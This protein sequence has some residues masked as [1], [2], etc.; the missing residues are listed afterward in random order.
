MGGQTKNPFP[1]MESNPV[2]L[3]C[4]Q[5]RA[6]LII[7]GETLTSF[8]L[9]VV[10][11]R[12]HCACVPTACNQSSQLTVYTTLNFR[13]RPWADT[14]TRLV[15]H[16]PDETRWLWQRTYGCVLTT[17]YNYLT[18]PFNCMSYITSNE[19]G[20]SITWRVYIRPWLRVILNYHR[21]ISE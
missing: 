16:P 14:D 5:D 17:E 18:T 7:H 1:C 9:S 13:C 4:S 3:I 21:T 2:W 20:F 12:S 6:L 19:R 11:V 10:I 8:R 15:G